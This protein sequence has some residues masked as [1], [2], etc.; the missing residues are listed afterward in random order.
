MCPC[1]VENFVENASQD[2]L[3]LGIQEPA[4][5]CVI[6]S[7]AE[8]HKFAAFQYFTYHRFRRGI[9]FVSA[10]QTGS[11]WTEPVVIYD[12]SYGEQD[13]QAEE[14]ER[15]KRDKAERAAVRADREALK[16]RKDARASKAASVAGDPKEAKEGVKG[17]KPAADPV[18][19]PR[20]TNSPAQQDVSYE[21]DKLKPAHSKKRESSHK[22]KGHSG[23][24]RSASADVQQESDDSGFGD[25]DHLE[26]LYTPSKEAGAAKDSSQMPTQSTPESSV[27]KQPRGSPETPS[28]LSIFKLRKTP[29]DRASEEGTPALSP[30]PRQTPPSAVKGKPAEAAADTPA[31]AGKAYADPATRKFTY[32]ELV[33]PRAP[34]VDVVVDPTC[35]PLYLSDAEMQSMI[36]CTP[37]EYLKMPDWKQKD[38]RKKAGLF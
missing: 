28:D 17:P 32:K 23:A 14:R 30:G 2:K 12:P 35:V 24:C 16:R 36:G 20:S 1:S 19:S 38:L 34:E 10:M 9:L 31:E 6:A 15:R 21:K 25:E 8:Q 26:A 3:F 29:S 11:F 27:E 5:Q 33:A 13:K 37:E 4:N 18:A 7:E 22:G